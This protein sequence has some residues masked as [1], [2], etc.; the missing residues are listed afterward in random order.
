[1]RTPMAVVVVVVAACHAE[2]AVHSTPPPPSAAIASLRCEPGTVTAFEGDSD[3]GWG[4]VE[5]TRACARRDET[6]QGPAIQTV[7]SAPSQP[8]TKLTGR[9]RDGRRVGTWTQYDE[10]TGRVLGRFTLDESGTG[11]EEIRDQLGHLRRG[12]VL[13]GNREGSWVYY[14]ASGAAVAT[15][16]WSHGRFVGQTGTVP[17]DPPMI[18]PSDICPPASTNP[19]DGCPTAAPRSDAGA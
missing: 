6:L 9:M 5:E 3:V 18:D 7:A 2:G 10:V 1:M 14:D 17:W 11:T 15:Q 13:L 8:S 4:E 16:V 19:D 12:T